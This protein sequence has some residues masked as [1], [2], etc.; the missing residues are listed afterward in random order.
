[1][2][3]QN[4]LRRTFDTL[5]VRGLRL[6]QDDILLLLAYM[7]PERWEIFFS[8]V[9]NYREVQYRFHEDPQNPERF[10]ALA[11]CLLN[12][13]Y[14]QP[15]LARHFQE[16]LNSWANLPPPVP[17]E[18]LRR[19]VPENFH[20][21]V[22]YA[23]YVDEF[24]DNFDELIHRLDYLKSLG[25][26]LIW[27]LPF[28][29]SPGDDAGYD[30]RDRTQVMDHLGGSEAFERFSIAA[31]ERNMT[32]LMDLV[33]NHRSWEVMEEPG[34]PLKPYQRPREY[35]IWQDG[36]EDSPP[37]TYS[38]LSVF[39]GMPAPL[40]GAEY[41]SSAGKVVSHTW[42]YHK[43]YKA[44]YFHTFLPQQ[45]DVNYDN[46]DVLMDDLDAL[47][48][49]LDSGAVSYVR[50]DAIAHLFKRDISAI[51]PV[52]KQAL[53]EVLDVYDSYRGSE[54][55]QVHMIVRLISACLSFRY[56]ES[57]GLL[58]ESNSTVERWKKYFG[59]AVG[60]KLNY[61][62]Y[63]MQGLW[64]TL[65]RGEST[66]F[67]RAL[68]V[69][70]IAPPR[71]A[72]ILFGRVHDEV[73]FEYAEADVTARALL[74]L[75]SRMK[76]VLPDSQDAEE[77]SAYAAIRNRRGGQDA[78]VYDFCGRGIAARMSTILRALPR[79]PNA[80]SLEDDLF[81]KH[82][83]L[84]SLIMSLED[85]PL[86]FMGDEW[87]EPDSWTTMLR[88]SPSPDDGL[89]MRNLH[90]SVRDK[91]LYK[92]LYL[93]QKPGSIEQRLYNETC[94]IIEAR[95]S[96]P[97]MCRGGLS[98]M[99]QQGGD[100]SVL[101]FLRTLGN[102]SVLVVSNLGLIGKHVN[103]SLDPEERIDLATDIL[104]PEDR[105]E[106][107]RIPRSVRL[108]LRARQTRWIDLSGLIK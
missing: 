79:N 6:D 86:I 15:G 64:G 56:G 34:K 52:V 20:H 2:M 26:T 36:P 100:E 4:E 62:F 21:D 16:R 97:V 107:R 19:R 23:L 10:M 70:D 85:I 99:T 84:M 82:S 12:M 38:R 58:T 25:V 75:K 45:P 93:Q 29:D 65:M 89:D 63:R 48:Y 90:R 51:D 7:P 59:E 46:P 102:Q 72:G 30:Q 32:I 101:K 91:N 3:N 69:S 47:A 33:I 1:M 22:V 67:A 94:R 108:Y 71:C 78:N 5:D 50:L 57:V 77:M 104:E 87:G 42:S 76:E 27:L 68:A 74:Q 88:S 9:R 73:T 14:G 41:L 28:L 24:A 17:R 105:V 81:E 18:G 98:L 39:D 13:T 40:S 31:A 55:P 95:K 83:L 66:P 37:N 35:F 92:S 61:Q 11:E 96:S 49:W 8:A 54:L 53:P 106:L 43:G 103:V 80:A 60:A 44:W